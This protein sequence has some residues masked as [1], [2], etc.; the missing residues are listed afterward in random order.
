VFVPLSLVIV[1]FLIL[2]SYV[3][4]THWYFSNPESRLNQGR[5]RTPEDPPQNE[6][7]IGPEPDISNKEKAIQNKVNGAEMPRRN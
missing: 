3:V 2:I 5:E 6:D 7:A 1:V 4:W